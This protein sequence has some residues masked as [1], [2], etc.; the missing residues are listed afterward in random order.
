MVPRLNE[1]SEHGPPWEGSS[2]TSAASRG[3]KSKNLDEIAEHIGGAG[4]GKSENR[5]G[6]I[7]HLQLGQF[8][9][10]GTKNT[11]RV[12]CGAYSCNKETRPIVMAL[13]RHAVGLIDDDAY[14]RGREIC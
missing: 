3:R 14:C 12:S 6:W 11:E 9:I 10:I 5:H 4:R 13:R 8:F 7:E 1:V 2:R